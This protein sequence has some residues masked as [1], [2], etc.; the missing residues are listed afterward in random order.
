MAGKKKRRQCRFINNEIVFKPIDIPF[1]ELDIITIDLDEFEAIRLCDYEGK[2][3]IETGDAMGISR[4]TVQRLILS[5]RKKILDAFLHEKALCIRND[6]DY[7]KTLESITQ[8]RLKELLLT[9]DNFRIAF[10][11]T[12]NKD[13]EDHF[14]KATSFVVVDINSKKISEKRIFI[15][16]EHSPGV[17][18]NFLA[19]LKVNI[20]VAGMM[21]QRAI[22]IFNSHNIEVLLGIS[23]D[24]D[25]FLKKY[26]ENI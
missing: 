21:G 14:G 22:D 18:P 5:G 11:T 23:G 1:K 9:T 7:F 20:V 4:G 17:L 2:N 12:N 19:S 25:I 13:I 15:S 8:K 3:Q 24:I 6:L 10:P 16:P 26:A